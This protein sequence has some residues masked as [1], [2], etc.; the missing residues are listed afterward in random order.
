MGMN[1]THLTEGHFNPVLWLYW[2]NL[3][4]L[5]KAYAHIRLCRKIIK[6][7]CADMDIRLVT[8]QNL[9]NY[10]PD[11]H[12]NIHKIT[13]VDGDGSPCLAIKTGF[14]RSFLLA[15]YGGIYLDSDAIPLRSLSFVFEDIK[16]YGFVCMRRTSAPKKHISIGFLGARPDNIIIQNYATDLHERLVQCWQ[17]KWGDIGAW[18]LTPIVNDYLNQCYI[19]QE[20]DVHPIVA[21]EQ[22]YFVSKSLEPKDVLSSSTFIFMLYHRIFT[23][24]MAACDEMGYPRMEKGWLHDWSEEKLMSS[25]ILLSKIFRLAANASNDTIKSKA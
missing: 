24:P 10:L 9:N 23:G 4:G 1:I 7:V 16:R 3:P 5:D 22:K 19:Y 15:K 11:I 25:D 21:E 17:Y 18:A 20:K 13:L 12:P 14:I 8:P 2:E 6:S